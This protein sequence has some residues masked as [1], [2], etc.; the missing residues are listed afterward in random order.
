MKCQTLKKYDIFWKNIPQGKVD[1]YSG[2]AYSD[3]GGDDEYISE[4]GMGLTI[5]DE[6]LVSLCGPLLRQHQV[7]RPA[8]PIYIAGK[9]LLQLLLLLQ[10]HE[11][12]PR[13][14]AL[15]LLRKLTAKRQRLE[16]KLQH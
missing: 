16:L 14:H 11:P 6:F 7:F 5:H 9:F 13:L 15:L 10:C 1:P 12:G 8:D 4:V 3:D 2:N